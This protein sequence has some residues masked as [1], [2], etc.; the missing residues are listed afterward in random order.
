MSEGYVP[1]VYPKG[2]DGDK[3]A[4]IAVVAA[5]DVSEYPDRSLYRSE[6]GERVNPGTEE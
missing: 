4:R 2:R 6:I 1:D 5:D 3:E